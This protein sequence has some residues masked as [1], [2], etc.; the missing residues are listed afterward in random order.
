[1]TESMFVGLFVGF[2]AGGCCMAMLMEAL[3]K[4]IIKWRNKK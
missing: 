1:M 3:P 4:L 2:V